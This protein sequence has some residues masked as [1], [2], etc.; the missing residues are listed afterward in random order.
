M[1]FSKKKGPDSASGPGVTRTVSPAQ[2]VAEQKVTM[3]AIVLGAVASIGG[4]MFGYV[5]YVDLH[6]TACP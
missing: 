3:L 4:F 2:V 6:R 1:L 5:R